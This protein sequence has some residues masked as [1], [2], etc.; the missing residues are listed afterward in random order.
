MEFDEHSVY[1]KTGIP[2]EI[3]MEIERSNQLD[4]LYNVFRSDEIKPVHKKEGRIKRP[5]FLSSYGEKIL[6]RY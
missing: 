6:F 4:F 5:S 3:V 2:S 1:D